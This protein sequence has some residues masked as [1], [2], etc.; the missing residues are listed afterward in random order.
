[1]GP[2][3]PK[4]IPRGNPGNAGTVVATPMFVLSRGAAAQQWMCAIV[5]FDVKPLNIALIVSVW[6]VGSSTIVAR[7]VPG[8]A[9]GGFSFAPDRVAKKVI[10][11]AWTAGAD[12]ICAAIMTNAG[13]E[14]SALS[15]MIFL[16]RH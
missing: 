4:V 14:M 16:R 7:P 13:E 11:S 3:M 10:G 12:S 6:A 2:Y 1:M 8:E 5:S 15:V 9:L